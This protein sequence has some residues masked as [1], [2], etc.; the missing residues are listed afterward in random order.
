MD[1]VVDTNILF[2]ALIKE[3]GLT[4]EL[5]LNNRFSL[6]TVEFFFEE[7]FNNIDEIS[8]KTGLSKGLLIEKL[9]KL[10]R[11]ANIKIIPIEEVKDYVEEAKEISP[12]PDDVLYFTLALKLKCAIW[13][14]DKKL[15]EQRHV[16]VY[17]TNEVIRLI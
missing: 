10:I 14:D 13:S 2:S 16:K 3:E 6:Y 5:L 1:L 8:E 4:R 17:S 7:F 12:D 11:L 9:R 15:K